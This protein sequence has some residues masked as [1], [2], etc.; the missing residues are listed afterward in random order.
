MIYFSNIK[1]IDELG[2]IVIPKDIRKS[3]SI[4]TNDSLNISI[5]GNT[6]SLEKNVSIKNYDKE[7]INLAILFSKCDIKLLVTNRDKVIFN[8]TNI[9][10][11]NVPSLVDLS[12]LELIDKKKNYCNDCDIRPIIIDSNSEGLVIVLN[13]SCNLLVGKLFNMILTTILDISC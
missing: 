7:A 3:L 4:K 11:I 5:V 10:D 2:R 9:I 13:S 12:L 8:N 1:K 6:I